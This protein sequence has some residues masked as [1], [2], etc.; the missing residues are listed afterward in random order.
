LDEKQQSA[1]TAALHGSNR[2]LGL[3]LVFARSSSRNSRHGVSC[4][5]QLEWDRP[6]LRRTVVDDLEPCSGNCIYQPLSRNLAGV[7]LFSGAHV[8]VKQARALWR[9]VDVNNEQTPARPRDPCRLVDR[10]DANRGQEL[11]QSVGSHHQIELVIRER[12]RSRVAVNEDDTLKVLLCGSA[13]SDGEHLRR[14]V[15]SVDLAGGVRSGNEPRQIARSR[16]DL[17][18]ASVLSGHKFSEALVR[19]PGKVWIDRLEDGPCQEELDPVRD[20]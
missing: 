20:H 2:F 16:A 15:K 19:L 4:L 10:R 13:F 8:G 7:G 14:E 17:E 11:V 6:R 3:L 12:Q 18:H 1:L 9:G 5:D